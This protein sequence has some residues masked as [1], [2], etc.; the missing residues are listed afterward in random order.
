[1]DVK[2][3]LN[4]RLNAFENPALYKK[5]LSKIQPDFYNLRTVSAPSV[6]NSIK[7]RVNKILKKYTIN[8]EKLIELNRL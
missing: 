3:Y 6:Y 8:K 2:F 4:S 7:S 5:N 1:M